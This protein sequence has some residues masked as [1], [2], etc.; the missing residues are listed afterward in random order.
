MCLHCLRAKGVIWIFYE[1]F[2]P[3]GAVQPYQNCPRCSRILT[4]KGKAA[5]RLSAK[6][7]EV[8]TV[9]IESKQEVVH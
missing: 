9:A 7:G 1:Y 3:V 4:G 8:L 5:D 2:W 6:I